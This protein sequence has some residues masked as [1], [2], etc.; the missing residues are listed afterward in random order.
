MVADGMDHAGPIELSD[1]LGEIERGLIALGI[2]D[3]VHGQHCWRL[4]VQ[5]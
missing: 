3:G 2:Q 5:V 4:S 1:L